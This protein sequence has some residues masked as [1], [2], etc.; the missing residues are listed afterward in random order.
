MINEV[1]KDGNGEIDFQEFLVMMS[2]FGNDPEI[3]EKTVEAFQVFDKNKKGL[4]HVN[5]LKSI[6]VK[7]GDK[8][9]NEQVN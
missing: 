4:I 1:D 5:D 6:L 3:V 2:K 9:S 7:F 8:S